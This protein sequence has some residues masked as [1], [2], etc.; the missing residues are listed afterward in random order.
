MKTDSI[1]HSTYTKKYY[2]EKNLINNEKSVCFFEKYKNHQKG[3]KK[4]PFSKWISSSL[5][6]AHKI[7]LIRIVVYTRVTLL[8]K[9][10]PQICFIIE[11]M[12]ERGDF[13]Q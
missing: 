6:H 7:D 3:E 10:L 1:I 8:A 4:N 2:K 11:W 5:I 12:E 13:A 9:E